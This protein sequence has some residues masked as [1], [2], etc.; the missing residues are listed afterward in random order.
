[1]NTNDARIVQQ[2]LRAEDRVEESGL[3]LDTTDVGFIIWKPY[4]EGRVCLSYVQTV[5]AVFAFMDGWNA[6]S[7]HL[8]PETSCK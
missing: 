8:T 4:E 7:K 6:A 3:E 2:F 5:E 1:M